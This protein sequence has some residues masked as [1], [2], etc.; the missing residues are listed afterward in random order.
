MGVIAWRHAKLICTLQQKRMARNRGMTQP[1]GLSS[2]TR[3]LTALG[4]L[5]RLDHGWEAVGDDGS[6]C[7][8][9]RAFS[10]STDC[11]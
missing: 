7:L 9:L 10:I 8:A 6:A 3:L 2:F 5:E 11:S 4:E 1:G